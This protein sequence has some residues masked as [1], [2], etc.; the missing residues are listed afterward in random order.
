MKQ[1]GKILKFEL[2]NYAKNKAFVGITIF[3]MFFLMDK[4]DWLFDYLKTPE[5]VGDIA[6]WVYIVGVDVAL[7]FGTARL[8]DKKVSL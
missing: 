5:L 3:L 8:M 6:E 4:I 2:N 1:F 7:F